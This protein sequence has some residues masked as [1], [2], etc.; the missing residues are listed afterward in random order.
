MGTACIAKN[1]QFGTHSQS[2]AQE[3]G[4]PVQIV[5]KFLNS[6]HCLV[7]LNTVNCQKIL[8]PS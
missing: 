4:L 1:F 5:R 3:E 2:K 8:N 6:K 7:F